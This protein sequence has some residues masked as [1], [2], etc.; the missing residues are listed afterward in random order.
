MRVVTKTT[1]IAV[2]IVVACAVILAIN[3]RHKTQDTRHKNQDANSNLEFRISKFPP[4]VDWPMFRGEQ[5]LLGIAQDV[6]PDKINIVWK[7]KTN[8]KIKS[9][10]VIKDGLVFI[11]STDANIYAIDLADGHQVW[12]YQTGNAVEATPCVVEGAVFIGS[13]D[14]FLYAIDAK[15]GK[16]LWK[17][18]TDGRILGAAELDTTT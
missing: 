17:Y 1:L 12:A 8:G 16:L 9:S 15:A 5:R 2:I 6:L 4:E 14:H 18:E 10:P 11:G 7:F 3:A 13:S